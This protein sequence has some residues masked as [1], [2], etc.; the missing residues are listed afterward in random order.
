MATL[1]GAGEV[2]GGGCFD[3]G[4]GVEDVCDGFC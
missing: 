3:K 4:V 1:A 2:G